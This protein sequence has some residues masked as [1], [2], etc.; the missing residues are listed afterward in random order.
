MLSC[1]A[2]P[3]QI[4]SRADLEKKTRP[5]SVNK[6]IATSGHSKSDESSETQASPSFEIPLAPFLI[7]V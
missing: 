2:C 5:D 4:I 1:K 6:M 7:S 3:H